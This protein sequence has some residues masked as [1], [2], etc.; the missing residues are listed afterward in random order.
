MLGPGVGK[1]N[2]GGRRIEQIFIEVDRAKLS[3]TG[4]TKSDIQS[5]LS[6]QNLVTDAGNVRI[7]SEYLRISTK[8]EDTQSLASLANMLIGNIDGQLV[9]LQGVATISKG[10]ADPPQHLY[11]FNGQTALTLGISFSTGIN[12]VEVGEAIESRLLELERQRPIGMEIGAIYNQSAQVAASVD[13]FQISLVQAV[14][15][16]VVVLLFTMGLR[17]GILMSDVL[18]LTILGTFILMSIY[19]LVRQGATDH[20]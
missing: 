10:Y 4:Y 9:Y 5:L 2:I 20:R 13:D 8:T 7:G 6:T 11:R 18:L 1:V 19:D 15:I 14:L 16:V 3:A 17:P 12:V